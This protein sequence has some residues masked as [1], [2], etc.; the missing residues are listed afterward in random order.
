MSARFAKLTAWVA[1]CV[2]YGFSI[3]PA[4]AQV[5]GG[6]GGF[7]GGIVTRPVAGVSIDSNGVVMSQNVALD[8]NTRSKIEAA[9]KEA[10]SNNDLDSKSELRLVSLRGLEAAIV[11]ARD[12]GQPLSPEVRFMAGLQRIEY[13]I[14]A[15]ESNDI[16]IGGPAEGLKVNADGSVVGSVTGAPAIHLED[17]LSAIRSS[18]AARTGYG[19]SVSIDPT[20]TGT[21]AYQKLM[22]TIRTQNVSFRPEMSREIER[23]MGDHLVSLTGV[24]E[25]SRFAQVLVAA[26]Y[27]MK[28]LSMGFEKSPVDGMPSVMEMAAAKKADMTNAAPRFWMEC[29]YQPV[30]KSEDAKVWQ[31]RGQAVKAMTE[32]SRFDKDGKRT[33]TGKKNAFA[34]KWADSMTEK[35]EELSQKEPSF[36]ELRNVMDMSVIAA[37]ID[38]ENLLE[39]AQLEI[40]AILGQSD[41]QTP[42]WNVPQKVPTQCS[43]IHSGKAWLIS[44]SGGVQLDPWGVAQNEEVVPQ[45]NEMAQHK[46][47]GATQWWWNAR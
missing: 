27:K 31:I 43:Y 15:P 45:L 18:E 40:P 4:M 9:L 8:A 30:A 25:D 3:A 44:A 47:A 12:A 35:F 14:L 10:Q 6:G 5:I 29:N 36:R 34:T 37:I 1:I 11:A 22:Q 32:E 26:D 42:S 41:L 19:I 2:F 16:I 23:T 38:R 20:E 21:Q 24:P 46:S 13:V 28:R 17:F 39:K 33:L 7:V